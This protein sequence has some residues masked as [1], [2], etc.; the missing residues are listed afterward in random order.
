MKRRKSEKNPRKKLK[1]RK[2]RRNLNQL[3][4]KSQREKPLPL[5]REMMKSSKKD[6]IQ[7]TENP[8]E[9]IIKVITEE[10]V[11]ET[12]R[13]N[14][15]ADTPQDMVEETTTLEEEDTIPTD[16]E[17]TTTEEEI[18]EEILIEEADTR[19]MIIDQEETM[20]ET[21][22]D[23]EEETIGEMETDTEEK[24]IIEETTET[25]EKGRTLEG[26]MKTDP[27][28]K[29]RNGER[30]VL[31]RQARMKM[32]TIKRINLLLLPYI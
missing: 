8:L 29:K 11:I 20:E 17:A 18:M 2:K 7:K 21:R 13:L 15:T 24:M 6:Q 14:D 23:Q 32:E 27:E 1:R 10:E 9:M 4:K 5:P 31:S 12:K 3:P 30:G 22:I 26:D 16:I 25:G 19:I 28:E